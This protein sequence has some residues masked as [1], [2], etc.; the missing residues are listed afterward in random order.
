MI[1]YV[2]IFTMEYI[3]MVVESFL[4]EETQGKE[5]DWGLT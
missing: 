2:Q 4:H 5:E 1:K 3:S